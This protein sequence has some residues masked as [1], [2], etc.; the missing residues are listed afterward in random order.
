V[1]YAIE[2]PKFQRL[3][4]LLDKGI[5]KGV[6]CLCWDRISRNEHD[7]IIIKRLMDNGVDFRFV[8]VTYDKTSSG[9]LHRDI[10]GMFSQHYSR[11]ISEKVRDTFKKFRQ[12]GRCLGPAPIGYLVAGFFARIKFSDDELAEIEA[13][14]GGLWIAS[15]SSVKQNS[16]I[17]SANARKFMRI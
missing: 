3:M 9:A 1:S 2:R 11:V 13:G 15:H 7:G 10:D 17:W 4:Q 14:A 8:Q 5:Y 6:I 16:P 12:D